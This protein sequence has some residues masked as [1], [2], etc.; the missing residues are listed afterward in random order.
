MAIVVGRMNGEW[1]WFSSE[2]EAKDC[3]AVDLEPATPDE[4]ACA[5]RILKSAPPP[6]ASLGERMTQLLALR[7]AP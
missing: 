1:R 3:G 2:W 7:E 4:A 5:A 6:V